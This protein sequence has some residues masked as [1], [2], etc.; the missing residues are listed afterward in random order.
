MLEL[1]VE[2]HG[3]EASTTS[4][5]SPASTPTP[6]ASGTGASRERLASRELR[7]LIEGLVRPRVP[8]ADLDD[9]VQTVLCD[10]LAAAELPDDEAALRNWIV[11]VTRHKIADFHRKRARHPTAELPDEVPGDAATEEPAER[12]LARWAADQVAGSEEAQRTLAWMEREGGGEKL[13][14]IAAEEKLP[15]DQVRQRV[16]RLRRFMRQRWAAELAA[17]AMVI[18]ALTWLWWHYRAPQPIAK[19]LPVPERALDPTS[20][21]ALSI[22]PPAPPAPS[23]PAPLPSASASTKQSSAQTPLAPVKK[24]PNKGEPTLKPSS[25]A[26]ASSPKATPATGFGTGSG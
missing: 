7:R 26:P 16:S 20:R 23:A 21:P 6:R 9:V 3:L 1:H 13:A 4:S 12:D 14:H 17:V 18:A 24:W 10:A 25:P 2:R 11:S 22:A 5:E 15:A 8:A 19:P